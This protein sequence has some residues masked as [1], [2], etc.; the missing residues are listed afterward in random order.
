MTQVKH[1]KAHVSSYVI[2]CDF[3]FLAVETILFVTKFMQTS[4]R[5]VNLSK[6]SIL[7]SVGAVVELVTC[8]NGALNHEK[9]KLRQH[10]RYLQYWFVLP[11]IPFSP[12]VRH[13]VRWV[14]KSYTVQKDS[15]YDKQKQNIIISSQVFHDSPF[16]NPVKLLKNT[17]TLGRRV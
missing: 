10:F 4:T 15:S 5:I 3:F 8:D 16:W 1:R 11:I 7:S 14:Q 17:A 6:S 13:L 12:T 2:F 9:T